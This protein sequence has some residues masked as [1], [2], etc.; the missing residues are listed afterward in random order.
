MVGW[1]LLM[2]CSPENPE[3]SYSTLLPPPHSR[4]LLLL[5][6][7]VAAD[8]GAVLAGAARAHLDDVAVGADGGRVTLAKRISI[9]DTGSTKIKCLRP[10]GSGDG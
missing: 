8:D 7:S 3:S 4:A 9:S 1:V 6:D 2:W 5:A 10:K